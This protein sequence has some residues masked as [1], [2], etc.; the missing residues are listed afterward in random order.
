MHYHAVLRCESNRR[1]C[2]KHHRL[3][4]SWGNREARKTPRD[5]L[6]VSRPRPTCDG[7]AEWLEAG[8]PPRPLR[9]KRRFAALLSE[10]SRCTARRAPCPQRRTSST[11]RSA[12]LRPSL[13]NWRKSQQPDEERKPRP[14]VRPLS[15]TSAVSAAPNACT[16][17]RLGRR[18]HP[19]TSPRTVTAAT[20][21]GCRA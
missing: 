9:C 1:G 15:P 8:R 10:R 17:V 4:V 20:A 14:F 11:C 19:E 2:P 12:S 7:D 16:R 13:L 3:I 21:G 5:R 6:L 18:E